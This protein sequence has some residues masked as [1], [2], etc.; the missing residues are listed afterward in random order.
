M[1]ADENGLQFQT[2]KEGHHWEFIYQYTLVS[3][4]FYLYIMILVVV[5]LLWFA[6]MVMPMVMFNQALEACAWC[7]W[8]ELETWIRRII[9][10]K[11]KTNKFTG[12]PSEYNLQ[13]FLAKAVAGQGRLDDALQNFSRFKND[14]SLP[15]R[16]Y[17]GLLASL[18]MMTKDYQKALNC[19]RK[20]LEIDP[21]ASSKIDL[22]FTLAQRFKDYPASQALLN[23]VDG[24][25]L[26]TSE[27]V[28][29]YYARSIIALETGNPKQACQ[30]LEEVFSLGRNFGLPTMQGML[31]EANAYYALA[32]VAVGEAKTAEKHFKRAY[33]MLVAQ[34]ETELIARC[35]R[36]RKI[37]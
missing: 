20:A 35:D 16:T 23:E 31:L 22:A 26:S 1:L 30:Y 6:K 32:L 12:F 27:K 19:Q 21:L 3:K 33:P 25:K 7:R 14:P 2:R 36:A 34:G 17:Y 13:Y 18:F 4:D 29:F 24:K 9:V 37:N 15:P 28:F 11:A 5:H 8:R 10:W